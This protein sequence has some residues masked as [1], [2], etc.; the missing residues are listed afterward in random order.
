MTLSGF[1]AEGAAAAFKADLRGRIRGPS[2]AKSSPA[3]SPIQPGHAKATAG[4]PEPG[5][6][7]ATA[8]PGLVVTAP[9]SFVSAVSTRSRNLLLHSN[10]RFLPSR[11]L[12][13][14]S[15]VKVVLLG[16]QLPLKSKR[17]LSPYSN[18]CPFHTLCLHPFAITSAP[19]L[20]PSRS[21]RRA[22]GSAERRLR[23]GRELEGVDSARPTRARPQDRRPNQD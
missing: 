16:S 18:L 20:S 7:F 14:N 3:S 8:A 13:P 4:T 17:S 2:K 23:S 1:A 11:A 21:R 6:A 5:P 12:F 19:V 15:N 22:G 10:A 9:N